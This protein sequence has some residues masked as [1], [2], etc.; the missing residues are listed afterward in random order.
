[1]LLLELAL[2]F[3]PSRALALKGGLGL[4]EG[5]PPL[6]ELAFRLLTRVPVLAELLLHRGE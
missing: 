3:L 5:R 4:I 1:M 6:L 2:R